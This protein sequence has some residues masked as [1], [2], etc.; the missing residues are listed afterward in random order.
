MRNTS[1]V[2]I[3]FFEAED[4]AYEV[5]QPASSQQFVTGTTGNHS[6]CCSP[7]L[8]TSGSPPL[9]PTK[10]PAL[11]VLA[12]WLVQAPLPR[13]TMSLPF[14][15]DPAGLSGVIRRTTCHFAST[16]LGAMH[17]GKIDQREVATK[18]EIS[19]VDGVQ[20]IT[21]CAYETSASLSIAIDN[22]DAAPSPLD[23]TWVVTTPAS[24]F[25]L[26]DQVSWQTCWPTPRSLFHWRMS[27]DLFRRQHR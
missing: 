19:W 1:C 5:T 4:I 2:G 25:E 15:L 6:G 22:S 12:S 7:C 8:H 14:N 21:A 18:P 27:S 13:A 16:I 20:N 26:V 17:Y 10:F 3:Q 24:T 11:Q 23:V 9:C